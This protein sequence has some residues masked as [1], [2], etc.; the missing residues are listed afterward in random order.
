MGIHSTL[1]VGPAP[2]PWAG[3]ALHCAVTDS[4]G[5]IAYT[6]PDVMGARDLDGHVGLD[7]LGDASPLAPAV[8]VGTRDV[9]GTCRP[10]LRPGRDV[11][12]GASPRLRRPAWG[13]AGMRY[14]ACGSGGT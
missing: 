5:G 10:G 7:V 8:L 11:M 14:P 6:G 4:H 1:G 3:I 2:A 12:G 9:R 13:R